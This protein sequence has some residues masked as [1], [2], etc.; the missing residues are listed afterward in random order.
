MPS[1]RGTLLR[2]NANLR[3]SRQTNPRTL[4]K[5]TCERRLILRRGFNRDRQQEAG[6]AAVQVP[7][8]VQEPLSNAFHPLLKQTSSFPLARTLHH[9]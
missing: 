7:S 5:D 1:Q 9:G 4:D 3:A 6:M 8:S 2:L